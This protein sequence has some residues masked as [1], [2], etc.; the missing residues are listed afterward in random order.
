MSVGA[1]G[2]VGNILCIFTFSKIGPAQKNFH[3]KAALAAWYFYMCEAYFSRL[4][5]SHP[6][7]YTHIYFKVFM[8][9]RPFYVGPLHL[10]G[11][12]GIWGHFAFFLFV[13]VFSKVIGSLFNLYTYINIHIYNILY[14]RI[15]FYN[16]QLC[17]Y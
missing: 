1:L 2:L 5:P 17:I 4:F 13:N 8:S 15:D 12:V 14:R 3:R 6:S 16:L 7:S 10:L 11:M 9:V